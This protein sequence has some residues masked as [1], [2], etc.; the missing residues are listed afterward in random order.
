[1]SLSGLY[2]LAEDAPV[3]DVLGG[4]VLGKDMVSPQGHP[5]KDIMSSTGRSLTRTS[6]SRTS[7][8]VLIEDMVSAQGHPSKDIMSLCGHY[9]LNG[10]VP[11]EDVLDRDVLG[12]DL[13]SV[14][15]RPQ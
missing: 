9:V 11:I 13:M 2:V 10:D 14:Q 15:G 12:G 8:D 7:P 3:E 6:P 4:D 1:M 5:S